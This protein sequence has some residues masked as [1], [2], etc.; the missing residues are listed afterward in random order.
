MTMRALIREARDL[1]EA[2]RMTVRDAADLANWFGGGTDPVE[3]ASELKKYTPRSAAPALLKAVKK[4]DGTR[5][6]LIEH[7]E[8]LWAVLLDWDEN[9]DDEDEVQAAI[10]LG[11]Y[12]VEPILRAVKKLKD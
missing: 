6:D 11:N 7:L 10:K 8:T 5:K 1:L 2:R 3:L 12:T 9:S 4:N